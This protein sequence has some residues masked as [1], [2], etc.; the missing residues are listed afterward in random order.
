MRKREREA[1]AAK[2]KENGSM[3]Q[4]EGVSGKS[5]NAEPCKDENNNSNQNSCD[6]SPKH[7]KTNGSH[8]KEDNVSKENEFVCDLCSEQFQTLSEKNLHKKMCFPQSDFFS[9]G[10]EDIIDSEFRKKG[11][12]KS[13]AFICEFCGQKFTNMVWLH[14]HL[15]SCVVKK[16]KEQEKYDRSKIIETKGIYNR[17]NLMYVDTSGV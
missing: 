12:K 3:G 2:E 1:N 10:M 14:K 7:S 17:L 9:S 4:S 13:P 5:S 11:E 8:S 6:D 15:N 16:E